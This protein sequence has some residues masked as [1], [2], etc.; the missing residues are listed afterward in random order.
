MIRS[1]LLTVCVAT[2]L[3]GCGGGGGKAQVGPPAR[4]GVYT[5]AADC[6]ETKKLAV[7][8]CNELIHN[9][10][11]QHQQTA[12]TYISMRLCEVTEGADHCER[13]AENAFR[14]KLQAFMITFS[15]PPQVE[16][17]YA[18]AE[19]GLIGFSNKDK[20]KTVL[21]VDE[22]LLFSENAKVVA[23]GITY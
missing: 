14:P 3:A 15:T 13:T 9:A 7:A 5:S 16:A 22:T 11:E 2:S 1:T 10:V 21:T 18:A 12:K 19:K 8:Q 20:S 4:V 17:L 23:E 6:A